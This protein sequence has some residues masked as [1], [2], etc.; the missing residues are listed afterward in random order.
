MTQRQR[1]AAAVGRRRPFAYPAADA[2]RPSV[3]APPGVSAALLTR[4]AFTDPGWPP[5]SAR[6][7]AGLQG[8]YPGAYRISIVA[9]KRTARPRGAGHRTEP[10]DLRAATGA[11]G[12]AVRRSDSAQR[13]AS[14]CDTGGAFTLR[15]DRCPGVKSCYGQTM[16]GAMLTKLSPPD[17]ALRCHGIV[18]TRIRLSDHQGRRLQLE[19][20]TGGS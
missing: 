4:A 9:S 12:M 14:G 2:H 6:T 5:T 7:T 3:L 16:A 13:E 15:N 17:R 19:P 20:K 10:D 8:P 1:A 11:F 18:W